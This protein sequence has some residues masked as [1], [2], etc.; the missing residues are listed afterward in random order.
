M[1]VCV[2]EMDWLGSLHMVDVSSAFS[3][4]LDFTYFEK[5]MVAG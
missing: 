2:W 3:F 4:G 1:M 5:G